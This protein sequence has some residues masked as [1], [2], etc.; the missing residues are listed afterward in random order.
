LGWVTACALGNVLNRRKALV[1]AV[2]FCALLGTALEV[3]QLTVPGR[4][5]TLI[6]VAINIA[7]TL[8]G[9]YVA[10]SWLVGGTDPAN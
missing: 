9:G 2:F 4:F 6:D 5:G 7:G 3:Y 10:S 1:V 8:T